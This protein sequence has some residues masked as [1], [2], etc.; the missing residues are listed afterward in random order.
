MFHQTNRVFSLSRVTQSRLNEIFEETVE[1]Y[2]EEDA[3]N[4]RTRIHI[5]A[6]GLSLE[7][8]YSQISQLLLGDRP[9]HVG[10]EL[11]CEKSLKLTRKDPIKNLFKRV[12]N[13][14]NRCQYKPDWDIHTL[15]DDKGVYLQLEVKNTPCSLTGQ[16]TKWKSGKRYLSEFACD[17]EIVGSV[18]ALIKDAEMHECHEWFRYRGASIYNPHLS[19]D[20]LVEV[21]SKKESF[22]V[23]EDSM[24]RT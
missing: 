8:T 5:L 2:A 16:K 19:P 12:C 3:M 17:Q 1:V 21:A 6:N 11:Q 23:R 9:T 18:F 10:I 7:L 20:A 14:V 4:M 15:Q 24:E 22:N 13:L